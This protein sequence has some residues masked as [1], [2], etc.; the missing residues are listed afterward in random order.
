M[1][2]GID[3]ILNGELLHILCDMGHGDQLAL[4]DKNYPAH[5]SGRPVVH[6][7]D[8]SIGRAAA[9]ILGVMPLDTFVDRPLERMEADG[10]PTATLDGHA[11]L[12]GVARGLGYPDIEF[13]TI[14][15]PEFYRRTRGVSVIVHT[16]DPR[17][18]SCFILQKGVIHHEG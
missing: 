18:Y 12:L 17:P 14:A 2:L 13:G 3:P 16:L 6:L 10:D 9:A 8:I 7:G 1:L 5:S 15:R 11:A 4:V